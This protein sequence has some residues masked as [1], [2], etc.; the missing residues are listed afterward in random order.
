MK[1]FGKVLG[2]ILVPCITKFTF[3][4]VGT[5]KMS[6]LVLKSFP[7]DEM[8]IHFHST[9]SVEFHTILKF[10]NANALANLLSTM[11]LCSETRCSAFRSSR[12]DRLDLVIQWSPYASARLHDLW[13]LSSASLLQTETSLGDSL[14]KL[15]SIFSNPL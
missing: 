8:A 6:P 11:C 13:S 3:Y 7:E 5:Q 1:P 15:Q 14:P 12:L 9:A 10:A 2:K 4:A